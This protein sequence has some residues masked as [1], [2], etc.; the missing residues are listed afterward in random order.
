MKI[1]LVGGA[2]RDKV[3]GL[4]PKDLDYVVVGSTPDEMKAL[5]FIPVFARDFPVFLHPVTKD[6]YSLA[7][8]EKK[9]GE[10]YK[11]FEV[12]YSPDTTLEEDL[13]R[14]DLTINAMAIDMV[15]SEIIDP[16]GGREDLKEGILRHTTDAFKEDPV[17]ILR[18]ARFAARYDFEVHPDTYALMKELSEEGELSNLTPERIVREMRLALEEKF[19]HRFFE[20][21]DV[22]NLSKKLFPRKLAIPHGLVFTDEALPVRLWMA[23]VQFGDMKRLPRNADRFF[24][25]MKLFNEN[26]S[27]PDVDLVETV[28]ILDVRQQTPHYEWAK[29]VVACSWFRMV[30]PFY[31]ILFEALDEIRDLDTATLLSKHNLT[32]TQGKAIAE[33]LQVEY[34]EIITKHFKGRI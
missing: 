14:R 33:M 32:A 19:A 10:G 2:V 29:A 9:V 28:K 6:E 23:G 11:G 4:E 27:N 15:S 16:F 12:Y 13:S 21:L 34:S 25:K 30:Q 7:R 31:T 22:N 17:R 8:S 3:L 24:Q 18:V 20:V 26:V 5:N 1:Y